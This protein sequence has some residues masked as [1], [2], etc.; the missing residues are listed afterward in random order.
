MKLRIYA[1]LLFFAVLNSCSPGRLVINPDYKSGTI[2]GET[3]AVVI[4]DPRPL[5]TYHG[6]VEEEFGLGNQ[7]S[8]IFSFFQ[9]QM[10]KDIR[11]QTNF[12]YVRFDKC[13]SACRYD[14]Q[15]IKSRPALVE[16]QVPATGAGFHCD[17]G[18]ADFVLLIDELAIGTTSEVDI[19][20][21]L[22]P[23]GIMGAGYYSEKKLSYTSKVVL[24]DNTAK[25]NVLFG[26]VEASAKMMYIP[27]ITMTQWLDV[28]DLYV[29]RIFSRTA[30]RKAQK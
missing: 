29:H 7:D 22:S 12:K 19:T 27:V 21:G 9:S 23:H 6:S 13:S 30:L 18:D 26:S 3:L 11:K 4:K 10:I 8:L 15:I 24:W 14:N 20:V 17:C 28:S 1:L 25:K 2:I 5:I 16:V